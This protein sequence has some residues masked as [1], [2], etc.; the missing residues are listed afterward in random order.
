MEVKVGQIK[1]DRFSMNYMIQFAI[2]QSEEK[3]VM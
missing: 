1:R 3:L 2:I